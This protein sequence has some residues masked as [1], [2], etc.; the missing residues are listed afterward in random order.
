MDDRDEWQPATAS[1]GRS[2]LPTSDTAST[3][4]QPEASLA[5]RALATLDHQRGTL[6]W[7]IDAGG[8]VTGAEALST[9][10]GRATSDLTGA[11]WLSALDPAERRS[12]AGEW[13]RALEE[14]APLTTQWRFLR[15]DGMVAPMR[16]TIQPMS[17]LRDDTPLWLCVAQPAIAAPRPL[18]TSSA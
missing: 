8:L 17:A 6:S 18:E 9:F 4:T 1:V 10:L 12:A 16:V 15:S 5:A 7:I 13:K 2:A 14:N 11:G 3:L